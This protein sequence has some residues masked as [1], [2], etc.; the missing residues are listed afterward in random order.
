M[1]R[2]ALRCDVCEQIIGYTSIPYSVD[3]SDLR[4]I[5]F[6]GVTEPICCSICEVQRMLKEIDSI[7]Q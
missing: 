3:G 1:N 7:N 5:S 6:A 2:V 4:K